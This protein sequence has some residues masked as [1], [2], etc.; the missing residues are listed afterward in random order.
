MELAL[1]PSRGLSHY[2]PF[3]TNEAKRVQ[4]VGNGRQSEKVE[5]VV[6]LASLVAA[7]PRSKE[8]FSLVRTTFVVEF[9][10]F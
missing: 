1:R 7:P 8:G 2:K 10:Q 3:A 4:N 6:S 5:V 9:M